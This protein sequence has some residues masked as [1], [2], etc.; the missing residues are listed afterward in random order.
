[1]KMDCVLLDAK[2]STNQLAY[3]VQGRIEV[4]DIGVD[5][6]VTQATFRLL[7]DDK[8]F[9]AP[10]LVQ[11]PSFIVTPFVHDELFQNSTSDT[12]FEFCGQDLPLPITTTVRFYAHPEDVL[13]QPDYRTAPFIWVWVNND[14]YPQVGMP[15][16]WAIR[17]RDDGF[18]ELRTVE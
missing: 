2:N 18:I 10:I 3:P 7:N 5:G 14:G 9:S 1:M 12:Q 15:S 6:V 13:G 16:G 4:M 11:D 8:T 17:P